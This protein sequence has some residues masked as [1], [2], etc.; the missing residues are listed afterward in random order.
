MFRNVIFKMW[1]YIAILSLFAAC[2]RPQHLSS[3]V[4]LRVID[5]AEG[6][7]HLNDEL[8]LSDI[9]GEVNYI[10]LETSDSCLIAANR[11]VLLTDSFL[12]LPSRI[13]LK[14]TAYCFHRETGRFMAKLGHNGEGP[15]SYTDNIPFHDEHDHLFYFIKQPDRLQAYDAYGHYEGHLLVPSSP[16][17]PVSFCF[18]DSLIVGYHKIVKYKSSADARLLSFFDG[19]NAS[20]DSMVR[21]SFNALN[22]IG[23]EILCAGRS[24]LGNLFWLDYVIYK[25]NMVSGILT[26]P[27][28]LWKL[29]K[30]IRLKDS[31]NDTIYT[32]KGI[33]RLRPSFVFYYG[34]W[35]MNEEAWERSKSQDKLM[36]FGVLETQDKI[37][38]QC[39]RN[40]FETV[41]EKN[42]ATLAFLRKGTSN[43]ESIPFEVYNGI[44]DKRTETVSMASQESGIVDDI[45]GF[46]PFNPIGRSSQGEL[47]GILEAQDIVA[48]F[49]EH[50]EAKDNPKLAPLLKVQEEDN[51]VV[52]IVSDK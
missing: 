34:E 42:K 26:S 47:V 33:H 4:G 29:G 23:K 24:L 38:F 40:V 15:E 31:F 3:T 49:D 44:Y 8:R 39:V 32:L 51:P 1:L 9:G 50:P 46:L 13:G 28:S 35:G 36:V 6:M 10:P 12:V 52:V 16:E 21:Y 2:S 37:F 25:D 7:G 27:L 22:S 5:I 17:F 14:A 45:H 19:R 11:Q 43:L 48:W 30:D 41:R 20:R 18:T